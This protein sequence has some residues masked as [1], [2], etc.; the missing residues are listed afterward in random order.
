[1]GFKFSSCPKTSGGV[2]VCC[3][4]REVNKA[5]VRERHVLPKVEDTLHALRG[6]KYFAK[7]DARSGFFQLTLAEESRYL[8]TFITHKGCFR[9]KRTPVGLSD[10]SEQFQKVMEEILYGLDGVEISVDD[11]IIHANTMEE[12]I[13]RIRKVFERCRERNLKLNAKKCQFGLTKMV[14]LGHVISAEGI[15]PDPAKTKAVREAPHPSTVSELRSFLGTCGYLAKFI[16]NYA[17][18]V[19]PLRCLTRSG[20]KWHWGNE[21]V[22]AIECL[23]NALSCEPVL[24]CFRLGCPTYLVTMQ[25]PWV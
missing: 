16:P 10:I 11:V 12:L 13:I 6:S 5:I 18:I 1:M 14:V 2:R 21:Q 17:K 20:V 23:K 24:A 19:E 22:Q 25:V 8:T 3:D 7:I 9:F 4:L 15:R